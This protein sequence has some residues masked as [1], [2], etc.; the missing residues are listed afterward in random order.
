MLSAQFFTTIN[1]QI[2]LDT[3]KLLTIKLP[4]LR[5]GWEV[6][7]LKQNFKKY[8]NAENSKLFVF[9]NGRSALFW[10]LKWLPKDD[11]NEI[12]VSAYTCVSVI[13]AIKQAGF[14]PVYADIDKT[15]NTP[16][17]SIKKVYSP[18]TKA[19]IVQHTFGNPAEIDEIVRFA[20]N[21]NL[22]VIED[23]AHALGASIWPKKVWTFWDMAIFSSWRDKVFSSVTGWYLLI[24]NENIHISPKLFPV[25]RKLALQNLA[26]NLIAYL[27]WKTYDIKLW[28]LLMYVA[29][30]FHLIPPILTPNEKACNFT[31]FYY[32]LPNS[33]AYLANRQLALVDK[34]NSHRINLA[35][36]YSDKLKDKF[37]FPQTK[38]FYHNIYFWVPIFV[39]DAN[40]WKKLVEKGKKQGI[41]FGI[42]W[43]GQN[44]VPQGTDL[45]SCDY[46]LWSCPNAEK[47]AKQILILPN[48][49]QVSLK[50]AEKVVKFLLSN[51]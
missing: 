33:L 12:I 30:K 32:Q 44:I 50:D 17:D 19:I 4:Y 25:S 48:H 9:Y 5:F 28:K 13:N 46:H 16:L 21:H 37:E 2:F 39:K 15:L 36:I 22:L 43:S 7:K 27:A 10:A 26:Y 47:L 38:S 24:N 29:N 40:L 20:H 45:K 23:C 31:N 42:Y 11:K 51:S 34:M 41:Y 1:G 8:L 49:Y 3:L 18:A 35:K 6:D 14:K